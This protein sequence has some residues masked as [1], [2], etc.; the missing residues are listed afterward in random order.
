VEPASGSSL[1][2]V[3]ALDGPAAAPRLDGARI[4]L[5]EDGEDNRRLLG[6]VLTSAGAEVEMAFDG[7]QALEKALNAQRNGRPHGAVLMDMQ[8]PVLDGYAA[9]RRLREMG[10]TLP[11]IALTAHAMSTDRDKCL[12]AGCDDFCTKPI[13]RTLF[14]SIV[15]RWVGRP[16]SAL[17]A[18][19]ASSEPTM[20]DDPEMRAL[21]QLFVEDLSVDVRQMRRA[22]DQGDLAEVVGVAHRLKGSAG[23]YGFPA[24]TAGAGVLEKRARAGAGRRE[25]EQLL[26]EI[27]G[28]CQA[29]RASQSHSAPAQSNS[30]PA[31]SNN[32]LAQLQSELTD[33]HSESKGSHDDPARS[34]SDSASSRNDRAQPEPG[35]PDP[36]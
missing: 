24:L 4:L 28:L 36:A 5:A 3:P 29:A 17:P 23:S 1:S 31:Q 12:A 8:M 10:Y 32:V 15:A 7:S 19:T 13:V 27:A 30:A 6:Y 9:T 25:L 16:G 33:S 2:G 11:I 22:L 21:V 35:E 18:R 20:D 34:P 14:L 26:E